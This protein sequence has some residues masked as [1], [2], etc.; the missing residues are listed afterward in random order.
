MH[1]RNPWLTN[2]KGYLSYED[3]KDQFCL[4]IFLPDDPDKHDNVS[5]LF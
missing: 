1:N 3:F 5:G 2:L 4:L